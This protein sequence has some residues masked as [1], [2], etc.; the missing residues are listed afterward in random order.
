MILHCSPGFLELTLKPGLVLA[1]HFLRQVIWPP[2]FGQNGMVAG[3][4]GGELLTGSGE[5]ETGSD[6]G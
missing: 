1:F 5:R 6:R 4:C 3:T 2:V